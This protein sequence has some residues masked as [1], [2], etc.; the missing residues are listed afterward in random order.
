MLDLYVES[1]P[2]LSFAAVSGRRAGYEFDQR[3]SW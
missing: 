1:D 2:N 3:V